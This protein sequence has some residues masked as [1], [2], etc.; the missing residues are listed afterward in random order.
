MLGAI[1]IIETL[2]RSEVRFLVV[3]ML[4]AT[5]QG[6]QL[7]TD[8]LDVC[9][10]T[11]SGNL[12]RLA[13][14]LNEIDAKEWDPHKGEAIERDWSIE[15]LRSDT[16]WIL[17]TK[18]GSLDL[19]FEPAGTNGYEDL[20]ADAVIVAVNDHEIPTASLASVIRMKEAAGR[21]KDRAQLPTLRRLLEEQNE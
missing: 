3:G 2:Q 14:V 1:P 18:H 21:E 11:T 12:K 15:I 20:A 16:T 5:L 7:R 9:P 6:S 19:L 17:R 10:D 13:R 8:D 4:A